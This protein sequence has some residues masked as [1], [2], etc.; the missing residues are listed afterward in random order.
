[1][2]IRGYER[3]YPV[4]RSE[5]PIY[6]AAMG[7]AMTR[8]AGRIGDGWISHE[9]SSPAYLSERAVPRRIP[10]DIEVVGVRTISDVLTRTLGASRE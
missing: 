3:P 5:I 7:P 2:R 10:G 6:L 1:M 4:Q 9:L 8:L